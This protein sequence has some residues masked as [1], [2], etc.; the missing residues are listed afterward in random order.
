MI[1]DRE[2][3]LRGELEAL[4]D[5]DGRI[6]AND[7]VEW[8]QENPESELHR[9]FQWDVQKA[10]YQ[11]WLHTARHL[12]AVFITSEAGERRVVSLTTDRINGGGYR[13]WGDVLTSEE[14]RR[15]AVADALADAQRWRDR[16]SH[17]AAELGEVFAAI[18]LALSPSPAAPA[19]RRSRSRRPPAPEARP[20][21]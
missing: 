20:S 5:D 21:A 7:V 17:L 1:T 4:I 16:N 11:H 9:R 6:W 14:M 13:D 3:R 19:A 18:D 8:A 15:Q 12:I 2:I 10:A